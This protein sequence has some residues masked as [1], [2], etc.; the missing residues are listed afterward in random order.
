MMS[1]TLVLTNDIA[2]ELITAAQN[3]L[4]TAGVLIASLVR[5]DEGD[6]RLLS[7]KI[8]WVEE[9][10][11]THRDQY[12][13]AIKSEGYVHTLSEAESLNSIAIWVHTHPGEEGI[14][15]S[16]KYDDVVDSQIADLFRLRTGSEYYSA[17]IIS[18]RASSIAFTGF[19][20]NNR[21][22]RISIDRL[23]VAG[24]RFHLIHSYNQQHSDPLEI[25]DRNVRA[26]G[27]AV[28]NALGD[29]HV[30]I[31][32]CGGTGSV[33]TEQLVRLGVRQFTLIDPDFLSESN[34]TR[35]YGSTPGDVGTPK[36]DVLARHLTRIAPDANC[37]MIT[38]MITIESAAKQLLS[39]D[40]VF[41]CT[42]DN[43]GRLVLSRIPTYLLTPVIDSGVLITS[44]SNGM[45]TGI[46][47][48]VTTMIPGQACLVCRDRINMENAAAEA[49]TPEERTRLENEGYAPA[50]G[51]AEPAVVTYTTAVGATAVSEL[52]ERF[53]G[54][55]VEPRPSEV[56]LRCHDRELST[57][58]AQARDRHYCS[59]SSGKLG[60]GNTEPFLGQIWTA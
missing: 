16:S 44:N 27:G 9:S 46:D 58:I 32:G 7:R 57:N 2:A 59:P 18:P 15:Q 39:C 37:K 31:V 6:T 23:W 48:R 50:L 36:V 21:E 38:S 8:Y 51:G 20:E 34:I 19:L 12:Q 56:L 10:A 28:Q 22:Q 1:T 40:V 35:V 5:T 13:M 24:D 53:I 3:P 55:G 45:L 54:Y 41:G 33:I 29:I 52:L 42:D 47:G 4:E 11:Y 30:G 17:I 60:A 43:A 26:F 49:L 14:P 25:F